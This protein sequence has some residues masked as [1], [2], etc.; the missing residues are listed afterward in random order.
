MLSTWKTTRLLLLLKARF[1]TKL[2]EVTNLISV[3]SGF[4]VPSATCTKTPLPGTSLTSVCSPL[5]LLAI[6][7]LPRHGNTTFHP[8]ARWLLH[9]TLSPMNVFGA[10]PSQHWGGV[11]GSQNF[12]LWWSP[13]PCSCLTIQ[14]WWWRLYPNIVSGYQTTY[15]YTSYLLISKYQDTY[16]SFSF[17]SKTCS[18]ISN[19][20][21][22]TI[23]HSCSTSTC[24]IALAASTAYTQLFPF[25]YPFL[26]F[27][28]PFLPF[29]YPFL[30]FSY[31]FLPFS[32]PFQRFSHP[33]QS[34]SDRSPNILCNSETSSRD[35]Q[36][37]RTNYKRP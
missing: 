25:S 18:I 11:S 10:H 4:S 33:F 5:S 24:V 2:S 36:F 9:R 28:Y 29:S 31:P 8:N 7:P 21:P 30:P 17:T 16:T 22:W 32:Y 12:N 26:P 6:W 15:I 20:P 35:L 3:I 19:S 37:N 14:S 1:R 13:H 34:F 23:H 27:S